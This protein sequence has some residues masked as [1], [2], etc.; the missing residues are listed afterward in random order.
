MTPNR[1]VGFVVLV[2][3]DEEPDQS[4]GPAARQR[5]HA[6]GQRIER[7]GVADASLVQGPPRNGDDVVRRQALGLV[8]DE[9]AVHLWAGVAGSWQ[10][11]VSLA[12]LLPLLGRRCELRPRRAS[13]DRANSPRAEQPDA[14][15]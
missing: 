10:C 7:S 4:R 2:R 1:I 12:A 5:Q 11:R 14:L 15:V 8:D 13:S 3:C 6:G 9:N